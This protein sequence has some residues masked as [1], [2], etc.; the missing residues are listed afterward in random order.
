MNLSEE[1]GPGRRRKNITPLF[2]DQFLTA[3]PKAKARVMQ[4][5]YT[6]VQPA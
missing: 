5:L 6:T 2:S 4:R 3:L 1:D